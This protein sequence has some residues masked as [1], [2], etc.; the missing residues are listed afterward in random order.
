MKQVNVI[1]LEIQWEPDPP[2]GGIDMAT[3]RIYNDES[4]ALENLVRRLNEKKG[5]VQSAHRVAQDP[6]SEF[7][8]KVMAR[9]DERTG[10]HLVDFYR[11]DL[12]KKA[13]SIAQKSLSKG[14]PVVIWDVGIQNFREV[15]EEERT[16][17]PKEI[18]RPRNMRVFILK[19][20]AEDGVAGLLRTGPVISRSL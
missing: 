17:I 10:S 14:K 2:F 20:S 15:S 8:S 6:R 13:A 3:L 5:A 12:W 4:A 11:N 16:R 19:P 18:A 1:E 7:L 9:A